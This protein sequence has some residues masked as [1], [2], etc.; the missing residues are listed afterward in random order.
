MKRHGHTEQGNLFDFLERQRDLPRDIETYTYGTTPDAVVRAKIVQRRPRGL[1][2]RLEWPEGSAALF[3]PFTTS[4][5]LSQVLGAL[6]I[7]YALGH[8]LDYLAGRA[9]G[10]ADY[11]IL[12]GASPFRQLEFEML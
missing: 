3:L 9:G 8:D 10:L 5:R 6:T 2:C 1:C 12:P 4:E 7:S 11:A